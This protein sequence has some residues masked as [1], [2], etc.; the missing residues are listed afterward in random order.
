MEFTIF[1]A[2]D[3]VACRLTEVGLAIGMSAAF[4]QEIKDGGNAM[5]K[6]LGNTTPIK[7]IKKRLKKQSNLPP[8]TP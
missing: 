5:C 3:L 4:K 2:Q 8:P 6:H 7:A 1:L